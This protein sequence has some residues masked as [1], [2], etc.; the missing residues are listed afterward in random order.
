M[1]AGQLRLL[2]YTGKA[3][4]RYGNRHKTPSRRYQIST[5]Q[6]EAGEKLLGIKTVKDGYDIGVALYS[7]KK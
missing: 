7:F 2:T 3:I 1:G 6:D 4:F 5:K